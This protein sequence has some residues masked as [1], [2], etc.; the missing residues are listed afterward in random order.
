MT[1]HDS[2]PIIGS[3][4]GPIMALRPG[5]GIRLSNRSLSNQTTVNVV[6]WGF[7]VDELNW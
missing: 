7:L 4:S 1:K 3:L 6:V 5:E 2:H